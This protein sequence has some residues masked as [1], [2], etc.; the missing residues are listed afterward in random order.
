[1][2]PSPF[3]L[4][5]ATVV[6]LAPGSGTVAASAAP[7]VGRAM[8]CAESSSPTRAARSAPASQAARTAP[9]SPRT[10]TVQIAGSTRWMPTSSTPA[11]LTIASAASIAAT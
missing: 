4:I 5:F 10:T 3:E 6:F 8:T 11:A 9:T 7:L 1:M 2:R